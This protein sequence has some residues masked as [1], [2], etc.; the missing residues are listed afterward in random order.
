MAIGSFSIVSNA[1][2]VCDVSIKLNAPT[3]NATLD[4][5]ADF[6]LKYTITNNGPDSILIGDTLFFQDPEIENKDYSWY[7]V[8][9]SNILADS[10]FVLYDTL[11]NISKTKYLLDENLD[12]VASPFENGNYKYF[13]YFDGFGSDT[14]MLKDNDFS[15]NADIID[16]TVDC[17]I[18]ILENN[19]LE[20]TSLSIYPNPATKAFSF[21]YNF[22]NNTSIA[23]LRIIDFTGRV[24]SV[25]DLGKQTIGEKQFTIDINSLVAGVYYVE[26]ITD[27]TRAIN[28][29]TIAKQ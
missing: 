2:R 5:D 9:E 14:N 8:A 29:I 19:K 1:Q 23:T 28:K 22:L 25:Q 13:V 11:S 26:L 18:S 27:N 21:N 10:S 17:P 12:Y 20:A 4:C 6:S 24:V 15:N 3:N 7:I 16:I